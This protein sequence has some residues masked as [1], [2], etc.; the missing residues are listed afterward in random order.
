[1]AGRGER[2]QRPV[3]AYD[4]VSVRQR[5]LRRLRFRI[6]LLLA[7]VTLPGLL[8]PFA[9]H[10]AGRA[11]AWALLGEAFF[12]A[13]IVAGVLAMRADRSTRH[14]F[15]WVG[16]AAVLVGVGYGCYALSRITGGT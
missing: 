13:A 15:A 11:V 1:V 3:P 5:A 4:P 10:L 9:R 2:K 7:I 12:V 14:T 16:V 8:A 6:L